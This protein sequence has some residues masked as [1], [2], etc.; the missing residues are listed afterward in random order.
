MGAGAPPLRVSV[1]SE[2]GLLGDVVRRAIREAPD[3]ELVA[4]P[5][6]GAGEEQYPDVL[7]L[8]G[9]DP[10]TITWPPSDPGSTSMRLLA[11]SEQGHL[12]CLFELLPRRRMLGELTPEALLAAVRTPRPSIVTTHEKET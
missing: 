5:G 6:Q 10:D 1:Q 4:L 12:G 2:P 3:L 7:V 8:A 9:T 11:I